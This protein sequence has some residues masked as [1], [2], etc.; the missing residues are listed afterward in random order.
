MPGLEES[1]WFHSSPSAQGPMS[2]GV[3]SEQVKKFFFTSRRNLEL[4]QDDESLE[5]YIPELLQASYS[6]Y[7]W[8]SAPVLAWFLW[9]HRGDLVG[10]RVLELGSGTALPGIVASKCGALVTLSDSASLPKSLQHI[11]RSCE[12]NGVLSQVKVVGVTWGLFLS[13]LFSIGP[14]D[15]ILGS[16]CFYEPTVF[17]DIVVTVAF[18]L[19]RNSNAR[20][21][22][23]YQE[24]SA[25]WSI[26][27]LLNKWGLTCTHIPLAGLGAN[28]GINIQELMQDHTIHLLDIRRAS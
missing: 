14:L 24:R 28:S 7:T 17:E 2:D 16:D 12:L 15:L 9:E 4:D 26:E 1:F 21:L 3:A 19:E 6:F 27:H 5:I 10:K 22:C 20:F 8:P 23:T 11:K 18:L 13:G 25:D